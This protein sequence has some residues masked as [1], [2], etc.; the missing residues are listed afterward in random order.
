MLLIVG[1][2]SNRSR[3]HFDRLPLGNTSTCDFETNLKHGLSNFFRSLR[4]QLPNEAHF[5]AV[6]ALLRYEDIK[7]GLNTLI[8]I[9]RFYA[10][11]IT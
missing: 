3:L 5:T 1:C 11:G 8:P 6:N 2:L 7:T 9:F 10:A 4:P